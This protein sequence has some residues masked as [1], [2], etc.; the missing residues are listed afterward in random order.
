MSTLLMKNAT[1]DIDYRD[2]VDNGDELD[3][4]ALKLLPGIYWNISWVQHLPRI[5]VER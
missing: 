3:W 4:V 1:F 5:L 2:T